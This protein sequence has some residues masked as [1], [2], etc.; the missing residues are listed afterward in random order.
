MKNTI[1]LRDGRVRVI[2]VK[3]WQKDVCIF[4]SKPLE[5]TNRA[6]SANYLKSA[7]DDCA[8]KIN[9]LGHGRMTLAI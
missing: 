9:S 5:V 8:N 2:E 3:V 1:K 7:H 6:N 4:C